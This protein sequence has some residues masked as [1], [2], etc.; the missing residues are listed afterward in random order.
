MHA[1]SYELK[2]KISYRSKISLRNY[3]TFCNL[4]KFKTFTIALAKRGSEKVKQK[5]F[6]VLLCVHVKLLSGYIS[7]FSASLY[8]GQLVPLFFF[9]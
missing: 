3:V 1:L 9:F 4:V 6:T 7:L 8:Y 2:C 5:W